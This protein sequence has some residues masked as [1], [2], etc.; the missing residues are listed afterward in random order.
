MDKKIIIIAVL[1]VAAALL[2]YIRETKSPDSALSIAFPAAKKEIPEERIR[3]MAD[4]TLIL[5]GVDKKNIKPVKDR[6][7]VRIRYPSGFDVLRFIR[8]MNDSLFTY[9]ASVISSDNPKNK[10]AVVQIKSGDRILKSFIFTQEVQK[11]I[12]KG[13]S[14]S[15]RKQTK[16]KSR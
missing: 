9:D 2:T 14:P 16:G 3:T 1:V 13:V 15:V 4:T 7:D 10:S 12:Q 5:L 6:N 8:A 11:A